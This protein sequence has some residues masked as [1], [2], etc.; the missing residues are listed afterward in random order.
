MLKLLFGPALALMNNLSYPS[1]LTLISALF[2]VPLSL[3]LFDTMRYQQQEMHAIEEKHLGI[4]LI[5]EFMKVIIELEQLRDMTVLSRSEQRNKGI[6]DYAQQRDKTLKL[7]THFSERSEIKSDQ[8]LSLSSQNLRDKLQKTRISTGSEGDIVSN[9]YDNSNRLVDS[10]YTLQSILMNEFGLFSDS[11]LLSTQVV[12]F[13]NKETQPIFDTA[14]RARA[15]GSYFLTLS[16]LTSI[17]INL[18]EDTIQKLFSHQER[19]Q[20]RLIV[21]V[22]T[23][24]ELK[25][26]SLILS[27][28]INSLGNLA[29]MVEDNVMLDPD[30]LTEWEDFYQQTSTEIRRLNTFRLSL[31]VFL[32]GHYL[33]RKEQLQHQNFSYTAGIGFLILLFGYLFFAF[34]MVFRS[35]IRNLS[36]AAKHVA[37]GQLDE[38]IRITSNDEIGRLAML[39]DSMRNQLKAREQ[40]LIE[41]TITDG[42]TKIRNRKYFNETLTKALSLS[43]RTDQ[44]TSLLLIDIDFFKKIND[45]YGHQAGDQCLIEVAQTLKNSLSRPNDEVARYGGE[46]F[47][48]L[49]PATDLD[50]AKSLAQTLC[51][52]I[53]NLSIVYDQQTIPVTI[54]IGIATSSLISSCTDDLLVTKADNALYQAKE[55]G[56]NRWISSHD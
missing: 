36:I 14:G 3:N 27:E 40:E 41:I 12:A 35:S 45:N 25:Q 24:P 6:T 39:F 32:E 19:L 7:L 30:F 8:L 5:N 56:R 49:L 11:D 48:V 4:Q 50:G 26:N 53:Q 54:S 29:M 52:N 46:E 34:V 15:F 10:A 43:D 22:A 28:N 31:G 55:A 9:L 16:N 17:G 13:L 20:Q 38:T 18:L 33:V 1:K 2:A 37:E 47:A 42:L 23:Y 51:T 21:L 44:P